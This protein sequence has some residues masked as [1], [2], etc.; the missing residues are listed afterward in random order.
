MIVFEDKFAKIVEVLPQITDDNSNVFD[1]KFNWGTELVLAK[2]LSLQQRLSFP[3]I[4]LVEGEDEHNLMTPSVKRTA[5]IVILNE[6]QAPEEFNPYQHQYDYDKILQPICDNLILALKNSGISEIN[7]KTIK[8]QRVKNYSMNEV[9]ESLIYICNAI[10][11][12]LDVTF[13]GESNC[14]YNFFN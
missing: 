8:Y 11:L 13:I 1:V 12:N 9:D 4:W 3:L 6:S 5:R 2:Y 14:V 7:E 10:I